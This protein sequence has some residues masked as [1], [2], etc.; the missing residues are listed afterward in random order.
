MTSHGV[1]IVA[2]A[3]LS[4][5]HLHQIDCIFFAAA[6]RPYE[7]GPEREAFRERW[8]GRYLGGGDVV[9]L[10]ITDDEQVAGYLV[11][12]LDNPATQAR[13]ADITYFRE[14]FAAL[15]ARFPA[16]LHVNLA[17]E[18]RSHGI[19]ARLVEAFAQRAAAAGASGMHVVTAKGARNVTFYQ[20]CGFSAHGT[21]VSNGRA[22]VFLGREL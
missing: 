15:C 12:A 9:L 19:G 3:R 10:A 22:V 14:H 1:S 17:E 7:P 2:S 6:A 21:A 8:L 11:G 5:S 20:R 13:F 4:A 16:H 18:F